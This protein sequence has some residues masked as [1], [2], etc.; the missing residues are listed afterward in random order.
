MTS[1]K[2]LETLQVWQKSLAF[3][4][5]VCKTILPKLPIQENGRFYFQ[6]SVRFCYIAR[7]SLEETFSHLTLAHNLGYL[8]D[9]IYKQL[10]HRTTKNDT[11]LHRFSQRQ[12]TQRF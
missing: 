6:E 7:G 4:I 11:R 9:E 10:N 12:Q 1:D 8:N 5:E 2:G 3:A